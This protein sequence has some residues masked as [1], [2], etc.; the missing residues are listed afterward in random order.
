ML[1]AMGATLNANGGAPLPTYG[2]MRTFL[3]LALPVLGLLT[4]TLVW[5]SVRAAY[6]I[7][8]DLKAARTD[9]LR[10]CNTEFEYESTELRPAD[11]DAGDMP[12]KV[13]PCALGFIWSVLLVLSILG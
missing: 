10:I 1:A 12:P 7:V 3:L 2:W 5:R 9:L 13:F 4:S 6:R 11:V 8:S